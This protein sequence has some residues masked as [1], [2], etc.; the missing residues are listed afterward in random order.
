[1]LWAVALGCNA[2]PSPAPN[3]R[4]GGSASGGTVG[5]VGAG[6]TLA[7]GGSVATGSPPGSEN[8]PTT[9]KTITLGALPDTNVDVL[10]VLMDWAGDPESQRKLYDQIPLFLNELKMPTAALDLH[11]AVVTA[12]M[13]VS[14]DT[15]GATSCTPH[16]DDGAFQSRPRGACTDSTLSA[17]ATFLADDGRGTT[18]FSGA[19]AD[20]LQCI[21][22]PG[23]DGCGFPQPLAAAEHALGADNVTGGVPTPPAGNAG[24]LRPDAALAIVFLANQDDCSAPAGTPLYAL[25]GAQ[26]LEN[27]LGPLQNYRCNQFGHL[28][29]DPSSGELV[30]PPLDPPPDAQG[31]MTAPVLDLANC[32]DDE[33]QT[34]LLTPV[35]QFVADIRALKADP[36]DRILV[37]AIVAPTSPYSVAWVPAGAASTVPGELWPEIEHSCGAA[38]GDDVNPAAAM[39]PTDGSFGD[40]AVRLAQFVG[41]FPQSVLASICNASYAPA[42][43]T[44][45]AKIAAL[46]QSQNCL[47]GQ[48]Q[49]DS[50]GQPTC[51]VTA[52]VANAAGATLTV[53]Y[54]NCTENENIVPCWT[55]TDGTGTCGGQSFVFRDLPGQPTEE[56][57]ATCSFCRPGVPAPGC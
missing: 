57:T 35:S 28:C 8:S 34:G 5:S 13:G 55:L 15:S 33:Q 39:T 27:P 7:A 36:D 18:N 54:P 3:R 32:Q 11:I 31:T 10:F 4:G 25:D 20:V 30:T 37:A 26:S 41:A 12:D 50:Y 23:N 16:G 51:A 19:I 29:R 22:P 38:G 47:T 1:M 49:R 53:P 2:A 9:R 17:G 48:L 42:A 46:P 40:P 43:E 56:V 44:I 14:G 45:A 52:T 21:F 6:G 24:F